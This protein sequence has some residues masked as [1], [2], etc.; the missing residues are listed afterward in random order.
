MPLSFE[1]HDAE[2]GTF[3]DPYDEMAAEFDSVLDDHKAGRF[4][5]KQYLAALNRLI[6]EQ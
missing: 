6:A 2:S 5:N 1:V 3:V 4:T